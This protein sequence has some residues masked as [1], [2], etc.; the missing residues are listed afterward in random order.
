M[1]TNI[2]KHRFLLKF[3]QCIHNLKILWEDYGNVFK[4]LENTVINRALCGSVTNIP[5]KINLGFKNF[6][7]KNN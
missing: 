7:N 2:C 4:V 5:L 6:E 1:L 3:I